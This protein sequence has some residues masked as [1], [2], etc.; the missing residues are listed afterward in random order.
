MPTDAADPRREYSVTMLEIRAA[1]DG[2]AQALDNL[3]TRYLPRLRAMVATRLGK[4]QRDLGDIDDVVQE[5]LRDVVVDL[6]QIK[7]SEGLFVHWLARC[8]E[9]N[10][11]DHM[12]RGQALKRGAGR[13]LPFGAL[14]A[15]SEALVEGNEDRPSVVAQGKEAEERIERAILTLGDRYREVIALRVH[16]ELSFQEIAKAMELASENTANVLFLRARARLR[17]VLDEQPTDP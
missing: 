6:H 12:R 7:E 8:V 14:F 5:T 16:G 13:V 15:L 3:L 17:Q 11:R 10:V 2:D 4:L 1:Q 9:N